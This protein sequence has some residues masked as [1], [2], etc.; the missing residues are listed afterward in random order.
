MDIIGNG[1]DIVENKRI[2]NSLKN[3]NFINRVFTKNEISRSK[4]LIN[5][6]NYYAKRFAAKEAFVKALGE[7]FRNNINFND[8]DIINDKKGKPIINIS[9]NIK[10]FIKK[11][12]KLNNY[13][14][15]LSLSDEKKYS[16][17]YVIINKH[18]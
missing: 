12:F 8:I 15:F 4:K 7:G 14:I 9:S 2:R 10:K 16:I 3:K 18:K 1:V 6:T 5:K 13:K 17:A 11:K